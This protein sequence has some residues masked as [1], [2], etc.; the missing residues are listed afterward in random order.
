[1]IWQ[2]EAI[3]RIIIKMMPDCCAESNYSYFSFTDCFNYVKI[4]FVDSFC[5]KIMLYLENVVELI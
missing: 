2:Y 1:M 4:K 5:D 3:S